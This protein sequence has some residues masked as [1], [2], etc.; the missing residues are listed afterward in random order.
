MAIQ[1][2]DRIKNLPAYVFKALDE[3]KEKALAKG[4]DL[5][6]LSI[7]D[8][9]FMPPPATIEAMKT[10]LDEPEN[11]RYPSYVG[12]ASFRQAVAKWM[13]H[14]YD[15][16]FDPNGEILTLIGSKEGI[17]HL[18]LGYLNP[19]D[20]ALLPNPGFPMY[21]STVQFAGGE[22]WQ[23]PLKRENDYL[24]D[25]AEIPEDI[26]ARAKLLYLN[27]PHNPTGA[28][29]DLAFYEKAVAF[30]K[31]HDILIMQDAAYSEVYNDQQPPSIF[32]VE[33]GRD[34][35]IEVYSFS[36]S[37]SATGWRLGYA[38]GDR[39]LLYPLMRVKDQ[40]D[41]GQFNVVQEAGIAAMALGDPAC[42]DVREVYRSRREAAMKSITEAGY[43]VFDTGATLYIWVKVPFDC[44]SAV[45]CARALEEQGVLVTPGN[46][47]GSQGEGWFRI[48]LC[49]EADRIAEGAARLAKLLQT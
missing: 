31:A 30:A 26:A 27:Y 4:V 36:K 46:A 42:N 22:P 10:A 35:A 15:L 25:F 45:F 3:A 28:V 6:S 16:D 40:V 21:T 49:L 18:P 24:P 48:A 20:V 47:F 29:A 14:R 12:M 13:K 1:P 7:G 34:C 37:Y 44:T 41:S 11:H 39:E 32:Q 19:G 2:A 17:A 5:I 8:P 43:E 23:Y 38:V 33:G 9:D